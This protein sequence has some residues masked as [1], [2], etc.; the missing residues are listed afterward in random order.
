VPTE[1]Q[2]RSMR[3]R[4]LAIA[5]LAALCLGAW[6]FVLFRP[7]AP[8]LEA[9]YRAL[10]LFVL[11]SGDMAG[12]LPWQLEVARLAAPALTLAS[13]ALLVAASAQS[14]L[15]RWRARGRHGH[16]VVCGLGRRGAPAAL[17]LRA[18]GHQVVGVELHPASSGITRCRRAGI[19]VV[20]GDARDPIALAQAG[21]P[22]ADHLVLLTPGLEFEGEVALAAIGLVRERPGTP[23]VI[24]LE[25]D[26]PQ[27]AALLRAM[28]MTEHRDSSWR[29]EELDLSGVG[30]RAM[31]DEQPPWAS[32]GQPGQVIVAGT[33]ALAR[34]VIAQLKRR[35][36]RQGGGD[37]D[38]IVTA[39]DGASG[40]E[41]PVP[42][43]APVTSA[44]VCVDD[45]AAA[46]A[47]ALAILRGHPG[48]PVLVRL[49]RAGALAEVLRRDAPTLRAISL[50]RAVLTP[51]V[52]L[53]STVERIARALHD[54]YRRTAPDGDPSSVP[55]DRL[56]EPLRSSNRAQAAHVAEKIRVT[57]R[58][59]VADDGGSTDAFT[60]AEVE[61]LG[62][63]EH[64]RWAK[65]RLA[66]GWTPGSRNPSAKT[67]PYLGSWEALDDDVRE[68]DRRF[69][70][71]LPDVL[72]DAGLI[73]R[74]TRPSGDVVAKA[75]A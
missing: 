3:T 73:L 60:D 70:R 61:V 37:R 64:E 51:G 56:A 23:L 36:H 7:A 35:W 32:T 16:V 25:I 72:A 10:Q 54:A 39:L 13:A 68:I 2:T 48:A 28:T 45:D 74:R 50:D 29:L 67:S 62:R 47:T 53:D 49:E 63:L 17:A 1:L 33:S 15:D 11:E 14:Q 8:V 43:H 58:V 6:G 41:E 22:A 20:V 55:W 27:L 4:L 71:A 40:T 42:D 9:F 34:A 38:L 12:A 69:V 65:E 66:V 19:P 5:A 59:L 24:H 31:L 75:A 21:V 57:G 46:L 26:N 44:Y 52:V 30:A 18:A